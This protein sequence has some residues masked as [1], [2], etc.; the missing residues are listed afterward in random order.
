MTMKL[1]VFFGLLALVL[2][3]DAGVSINNPFY[4]YSSDFIR[5]QVRMH[6]VRSSYEAIR[7]TEVD[8]AVSCKFVKRLKRA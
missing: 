2:V 5:P 8:P 4:C 7:R 6:S 1:I 3:S